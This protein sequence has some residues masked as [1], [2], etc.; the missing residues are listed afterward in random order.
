MSVFK[1]K[2]LRQ[3]KETI[4]VSLVPNLEDNELNYRFAR[5]LG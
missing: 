2:R 5:D 4:L 1:I 3:L